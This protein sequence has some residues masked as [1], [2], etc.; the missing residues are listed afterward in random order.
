MNPWIEVTGWTLIHFVWQGALIA[1]ATAAVL[2]GCRRPQVRYAIAC[3][4]LAAMLASAAATALVTGG[5]RSPFAGNDDGGLL[6]T[7]PDA[8]VAGRADT[9][10]DSPPAPGARVTDAV[11]LETILRVVVGVWLIGLA[12]ATARL[13]GGCWRV[14]GLR[15]AL[16][17]APVSS[18]QCAAERLARRL[19]LDAVFRVVE[20]PLVAAPVVVGWLR[21]LIVLPVAIAASMPPGQLE[22]VIAHE[23]AHIRRRDYAVNLLQSIVEA[24]FFFHPGV[25]WVSS[26]IREEREHCCDDVVVELV[27]EAATYAEALTALA[28][29]HGRAT[30]PALGAADGRLLRRIRRLLEPPHESPPSRLASLAFLS[31]TAAAALTIAVVSPAASATPGRVAFEPQAPVSNQQVRRTDHFEIQYAASLDLHA[32]RIATEAERAYERVS[33]DLRHNLAFNVPLVLFASDAELQRSVQAPSGRSGTADRILLALDRPADTW[34]G[35]I[36][37]ELAHVF[38]FDIIPRA[39]ASPAWVSEGLAEYERGSWDPADLVILRDA[40]RTN[41]LPKLTALQSGTG[42]PRVAHAIGHAAFD[43][44]ESRWGKAGMRQLL[45]ALRQQASGGGDPYEAAFRMQAAAFENAFEQYLRTKVADR[46][47]QEPQRRFDAA[48]A[49][50]VDGVITS[51]SNTATAGLACIELLVPAAGDTYDR[52]GIECGEPRTAD[53]IDRLRPGERVIVTGAPSLTPGARRVA[54]R[55]LARPSDGFAWPV[56]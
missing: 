8:S 15:T 23:L 16:A 2:H 27:G 50:Q 48:R 53:L 55:S 19:R 49:V 18:W 39:A 24:L 9:G 29:W 35:V 25:W 52:W 30:R 28:A 56:P 33:G 42:A 54:L 37:H 46:S 21:P 20:S 4:G 31:M 10:A 12:A 22:A 13:A 51:M 34:L 38:E 17:V 5:Q 1:L 40:V 32:D 7:R 3:T 11:T 26:R 36:T 45:F 14:H 47:P 6:R 43:F 44:I 41:A